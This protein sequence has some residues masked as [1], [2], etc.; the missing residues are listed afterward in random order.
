MKSVERKA[1]WNVKR[2]NQILI[3]AGIGFVGPEVCFV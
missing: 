1:K 3:M 2:F